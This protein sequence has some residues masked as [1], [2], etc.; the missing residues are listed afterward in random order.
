MASP[1][2]D[3]VL[4]LVCRVTH[5]LLSGRRRPTIGQRPPGMTSTAL[6]NRP[7]A[8]IIIQALLPPI[9]DPMPRHREPTVKQPAES[10]RRHNPSAF[11]D[12]QDYGDA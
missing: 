2:G 9:P 11:R 3:D 1:W 7:A 6:S 8:T 10:T 12:S 5:A 4:L